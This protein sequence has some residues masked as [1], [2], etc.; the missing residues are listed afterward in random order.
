MDTKMFCNQCEQTAGGTGCTTMGVCGKNPAVAKLQDDL[1]A[2]VIRLGIAGEKYGATKEASR[3]LIEG[4]FVTISNVN[5]DE[6][7]ILAWIDKVKNATNK[8]GSVEE[9][10]GED[11]FKGDKDIVSLRQTLLYGLKGTAAY[12][13]HA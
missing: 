1:I 13:H 6:E 5:F 10:K 12:A 7:S 4:L 2:E 8:L 3:L 11:L 9:I